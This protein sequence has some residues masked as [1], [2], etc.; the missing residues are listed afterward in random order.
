VNIQS[1]NDVNINTK[2]DFNVFAKNV[3]L[4]AK[5]TALL[6]GV[7]IDL[8]YAKLPGTPV[9]TPNGPAIRLIPSAIKTDFPEIA[10]QI[11]AAQTAHKSKLNKLKATAI[12]KM[13][14]QLATSA[15]AGGAFG[16]ATVGTTLAMAQTILSGTKDTLSMLTLMQEGPFPLTGKQPEFKF[17][18][19]TAEQTPKENPLGN[20]LVYNLKTRA[21]SD[22]RALM[23]DTPEE[24]QDSE[25][26]Q[27][28]L[29]TRKALGDIPETTGPELPGAR[30]TL[31]TGI[32]A[33]ESIPEVNYLNRDD[34]RGNYNFTP[35]TTLGGTSFTVKMLADS[36]ARPDVANY[37][38][39]V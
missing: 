20:P 34:Y 15:L 27:A 29:D 38:P 17:P 10:Q 11:D 39:P 14:T 12:A 19:L 18:T 5:K 28:H 32:V 35:D 6:D 33:T 31:N 9:F 30:T 21:A 26:Y 36:L 13:G 8:R 7:E 37:T 25:Q 4:H 16:V 1:D 23:F 24:L 3:N 22:Y 2:K